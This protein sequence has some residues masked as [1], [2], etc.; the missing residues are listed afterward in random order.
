MILLMFIYFFTLT[1]TYQTT[2]FLHEQGNSLL[3]FIYSIISFR[4]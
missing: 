3:S 2:T 1:I 4:Q